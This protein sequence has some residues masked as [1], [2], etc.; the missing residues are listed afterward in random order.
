MRLARRLCVIL[1]YTCRLRLGRL[2]ASSFA[3]AA[4]LA[5]ARCSFAQAPRTQLRLS[6]DEAIERAVQASYADTI[7]GARLEV[8]AR[9]AGQ[10][11]QPERYLRWLAFDMR[12]HRRCDAALAR[13]GAG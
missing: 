4:L 1:G 13:L 2:V 6:L 7:A 11:P 3:G 12:E 8:R 9:A 5:G 10:I